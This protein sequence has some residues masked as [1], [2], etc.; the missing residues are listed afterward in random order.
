MILVVLII[1]IILLFKVRRLSKQLSV[2]SDNIKIEVVNYY[3]N[4]EIIKE[5]YPMMEA[6]KNEDFET[7]HYHNERLKEII[8]QID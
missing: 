6:L 4:G 3:E 5:V 1:Q 7:A 8:N 2:I